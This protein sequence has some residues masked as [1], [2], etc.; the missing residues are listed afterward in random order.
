MA[1]FEDKL[2]AILGDPEAIGQSVSIAKA[3]TGDGTA[4]PG[5][6]EPPSPSAASEEPVFEPVAAATPKEE[7]ARA[8]FTK[9]GQES[10]AVLWRSRTKSSPARKTTERGTSTPEARAT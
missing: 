2:H 5:E 10:A 4:S 3:L 8:G 7:P 6:E 1:E 9:R